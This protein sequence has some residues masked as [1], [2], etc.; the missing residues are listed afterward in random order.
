MRIS[1]DLHD[2][3]GVGLSSIALLSES[4]GSTGEITERDRTRL[5]KITQAARRMVADLRDIIW[6]IDPDEDHVE[7]VVAR[8]RDEAS[9]L[10]RD[11]DVTFQTPPASELAE[12]IGMAA[13]RDLLLIFKEVLHNIARHAHARE[14]RIELSVKRDRVQLIVSDNGV[15]FDPEVAR[16]GTGVKSMRE[17]AARLGGRLDIISRP[18][19][20]TSVVLTLRAR[21]R[22]MAGPLAYR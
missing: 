11:V 9:V 18:G 20:G 7:D 10:L 12:G 3:I 16:T 13:R 1:R 5:D 4:V 6:A 19:Q 22:A 8:M 2:E 14:V 17:R 21:E 15:G